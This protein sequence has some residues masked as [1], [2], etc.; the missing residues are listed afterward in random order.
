[1][2]DLRTACPLTTHEV[3]A[4]AALLAPDVEAVVTATERITY[5]ELATLVARIRAGLAAAGIGRG[6]RVGLCLGNGP[7]WVALFLAIGAAGAVAV[8]VNTRFTADEVR[9]TLDHAR[10]RT[11]FVASRV[12][13]VDFAAMLRELDVSSIPS[14]EKVVVLGEDVPPFASSWNEFLS[15][16]SEVPPAVGAPDDILLV[17]YTSGTTSRPK[18]V[19]L[20]HRGMC[21]DAFFSGAR[22]GLRPGDR[23]HS[24]R[25]FFHVAGSTLSVLASLQHATTLVT[26]PKFE[27]EEALR[28]LE[29]ERCTHFSGNDTIALLLLNH[30]SLAQRRLSLRG[31]WV[32]A[33]PTVIRRVIDELGAAECVAGYGLS[34]ASPNVAQSAWWEPV[35]IRASGAMA[36]QPGVE[37]RIRAFD[38]DRDCGPGEPGAV[39][40]RGWNVMVGYLDDPAKTADTIDADGWLSTGDVGLLDAGGRLHFTGRTKDIIRVGGENVAPADIE[41]TLHRHPLVRQAAVVGVPDARLVEVPFA[42]VVVTSPEVTEAELLTWARERMAGFK[43][44]RHLRIVEGF[45][46]IGMTA[47]SKVQKNRLASH[48]RSL[49]ERA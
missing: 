46:G 3:L 1:M 11:L 45:E 17:Q 5:G 27:P 48:A 14:L 18:G 38:G 24:A 15:G 31:A 34:E 41:D 25:P 9:Y 10:V 33:S 30:P 32:A 37:V 12:L 23:F 19:L 20:T 42:F 49:L 13:N 22:M 21:A 43:V 44:P 2:T 39:L 26:M 6:D 28:L 36:V 29:T 47:S 40:V 8:P 4:R 7:D 16:S 35:E